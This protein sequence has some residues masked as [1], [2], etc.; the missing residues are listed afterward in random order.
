MQAC[1]I[2]L[3]GILLFSLVTGLKAAPSEPD[4]AEIFA[5]AYAHYKKMCDSMA[6]EMPAQF[7]EPVRKV[8]GLLFA[9]SNAPMV[10]YEIHAIASK[11]DDGLNASTT[12]G[13][14]FAIN[15]NLLNAIDARAK[16]MATATASADYNRELLLAGV[17]AHEIGHF[18]S[19]HGMRYFENTAG[20]IQG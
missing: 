16:Q 1:R 7:T 13:P 11:S 10:P 12:L 2:V 9:R 19:L 20:A 5:I 18:L 14:Y 6:V 3:S 17:F 4:Q 8:F 15:I